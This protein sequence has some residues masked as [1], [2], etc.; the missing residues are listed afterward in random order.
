[1]FHVFFFFQ[2]ED[3]IRD[4]NVTGVQTCALP[5][6]EEGHGAGIRGLR[7]WAM[8]VD[9]DAR[10]DDG[11][12]DTV[13]CKGESQIRSRGTAAGDCHGG[14]LGEVLDFLED[15]HAGTITSPVVSRVSVVNT[16]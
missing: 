9:F 6:C 12:S 10:L 14:V 5:I 3:G 2:A 15:A 4:R 1:Y 11:R 8:V 13:G 7:T 16:V